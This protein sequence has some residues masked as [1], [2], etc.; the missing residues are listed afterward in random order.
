MP[1]GTAVCSTHTSKKIAEV[2][3]PCHRHC[4][5]LGRTWAGSLLARALGCQ[6]EAEWVDLA[7]TLAWQ[8]PSGPDLDV[9]VVPQGRLHCQQLFTPQH[10]SEQASLPL[11]VEGTQ[12]VRE[13]V[14]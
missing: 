9:C 1:E 7:R 11:P 14:R 3:V 12:F 13:S 8:L 5:V 6:G 4:G 2:K 10:F